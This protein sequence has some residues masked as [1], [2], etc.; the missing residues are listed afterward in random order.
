MENKIALVIGVLMFVLIAITGSGCLSTRE[1]TPTDLTYL[2]EQYPPFN[3][4]KDGQLQGIAVELL[5]AITATMGNGITEDA[6]R[7]TP[8]TGG[9]QTALNQTNTVLFSTARLPE[10]ETSFKWVGPIYT[11]QKVLFARRDREISINH[12]ADL[13]GYTIGV[14]TD[15]AAIPQLLALGVTS[16]QL[17]ADPDP[18]VIMTKLEQGELDL[19]CYG[20][21]AG[22]YIAEE[23]TG[24]Y[25]YF[26]VVYTLQEYKLYYAFNRETPDTVIESFQE[27]L[28]RVKAREDA[29]GLS[30]YERIVARYIPAS[31][32]GKYTYLTEEFPPLNYKEGGELKGVAVDLLYAIFMRLNVGLT[33]A[34]V[35]FVPWSEAYQAGR[36]NNTT[37]VFSMARVPE[38]EELFRWAG[39]F[40]KGDIVLFAPR[41]RNITI[42]TAADLKNYRI[43]AIA[44]TSSI[45]LLL[46]LGVAEE[47]LVLNDSAAVLI[48]QLERGE[49]D[50]WSTGE[51][52]GRYLI[53]KYAAQ[54][55]DLERVYTLHTN[56]YYFAFSRDT[57][58]TLVTAF[59]Q[60]LED[61]RLEKD[62]QG[63]SE[64]ERILYRYLEVECVAQPLSDEAVMQLVNL[65]ATA[66]ETD[67]HG[68]FQEINLGEDPYK[69]RTHQELY[70]FVYDTN[71]TM[72]AHAD[73]IKLVGVN[74][75]GKTDV[76]GK[77]FRDEIV[78]G[79]LQNGSGWVEYLY[80]NPVETGLYLKKTYYQ[81]VRGSDGQQYVICCGIYKRCS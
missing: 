22:N 23:Q 63:V 30:Q 4:E 56:E 9:Y 38:R 13:A 69:N 34:D 11:G 33:R 29:G 25:G 28:D 53:T 72:V 67:V 3:Y 12:P 64:Y 74:F 16:D 52:S 46:A 37:V 48:A 77:P 51:F 65:T 79:A 80:I 73:N 61:I 75:C 8:W 45:P 2:T 17:L 70:I 32:L 54:P 62:A 31:G 68:T 15:D 10:R 35:R 5:E 18:V 41:S 42:A 20:E 40:V 50:L 1:P 55:D 26:K 36:G 43:G 44:N 66:I 71:V 49:F 47:Q 14:I 7:L 21:E 76:T 39:P 78:A 24:R 59:Q 19:W 60:A 58:D 27:A 81:L 6:I 57:S